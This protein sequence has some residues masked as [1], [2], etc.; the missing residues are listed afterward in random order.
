MRLLNWHR[1]LVCFFLLCIPGCT[2][3]TPPSTMARALTVCVEHGGLRYLQSEGGPGVSYHTAMCENN[4][5]IKLYDTV[6][7]NGRVAEREPEPAD[8]DIP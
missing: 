3:Y 5:E 1:T 2:V 8:N 7:D 4:L 6:L